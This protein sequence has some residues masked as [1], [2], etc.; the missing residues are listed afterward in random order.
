[1]LLVCFKFSFAKI[2]VNKFCVFT[3]A[4]FYLILIKKINIQAHV[5]LWL[6]LTP[7]WEKFFVRSCSC[8]LLRQVRR[9]PQWIHVRFSVIKKLAGHDFFFMQCRSNLIEDLRNIFFKFSLIFIFFKFSSFS[10]FIFQI[11]IGR[12]WLSLWKE[13]YDAAIPSTS[14]QFSRQ[15]ALSPF[16]S[17]DLF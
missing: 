3:K 16:K 10:N 12:K 2:K 11:F 15:C 8:D 6:N 4:L 9:S 17:R 7:K 13:A 5:Y 1:M 14:L